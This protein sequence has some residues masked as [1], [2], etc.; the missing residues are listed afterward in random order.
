MDISILKNTD[1]E[2]YEFFSNF[3]FDEVPN[4]KPI[5]E[6]TRYMA[7]LATLVG[8]QGVEAF[9]ATLPEALEF[10]SPVEVKEVVYQATA[11]LGIG[12]T[13]E[14]LNAMNDVFESEGIE[15]PLEGQATTTPATRREAGTAKQVELFGPQMAEFYK[16][17]P[18][19]SVHINRWLAANCFGDYYTRGGLD[20][21]QREMVTFCYI[22]AQ[23]GCEPQLTSHAKANMGIGNDKE[24]LI[25]VLSNIMPYIGYPRTLNALA[26]INKAAE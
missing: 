6:K 12:R 4:E 17:G 22:A 16:S 11:Y 21:K 13:F 3:A 14:F 20:N 9:Y 7:I 5:D 25:A 23:G 8:C 15:M 2:F 26:C 1:P 18:Q 24:F 19:D 10:V